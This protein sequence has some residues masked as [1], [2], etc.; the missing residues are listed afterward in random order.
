M[1]RTKTSGSDKGSAVL[2]IFVSKE[3]YV[4]KEWLDAGLALW[5]E[6]LHYPRG[7]FLVLPNEDL[8][9]TCGKKARYSDAQG[10]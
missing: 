7:Y 10:F 8:S 9:G 3:A 5:T 4:D 2:P 1:S 6:Q